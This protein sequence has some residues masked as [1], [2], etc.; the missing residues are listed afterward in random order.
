MTLLRLCTDVVDMKFGNTSSIS[1][2]RWVLAAASACVAPAL[3]PRVTRAADIEAL[4]SSV[5]RPL[6]QEYDIPGL[7]VGLVTQG[8][9]HFLELGVSARQGGRATSRDTLFEIGS[10]S[11]C[12]T[13][14]LAALAQLKGHLH[15]DQPVEEIVKS[16]QG[17]PIGRAS[18]MHLATY[19]AGGLPLQFPD[20]VTSP[21]E[22]LAYFST[23]TPS[24]APGVIRNY[25]NPSIGLLG[26]ATAL[27]LA[28]DFS[29]LSERDLFA[30]LGLDSTFIKVPSAQIHRYAWGH[31]KSQ[32]QVRVNPGVFDAQ[33]YGV[34]STASD[35][36]TFLQAHLDPKALPPAIRGAIAQTM[37]PRY[38]AGPMQQGMGW[39][40]YPWPYSTDALKEGNGP[41]TVFEPVTVHPVQQQIPSTRDMTKET[42]HALVSKATRLLPE[43]GAP[44]LLN[45]TGS[46]FGFGAYVAMV[47]HRQTALVMLAN[48]NLPI[49]ARVSAAMQ[50]L[51]KIGVL[52]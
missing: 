46:T 50:V 4:L 25:S 1:R 42:E 51:E 6:V 21:Q 32:K 22:A 16:L 2:R 29:D 52:S 23:F 44:L 5:Y 11:K 30:P 18:L 26:H 47:P 39:E 20:Q 40:I 43:R 41:R 37:A 45:K 34:K 28:G 14:T 36:L 48:R 27:A 38:Q 31:D 17:A 19:T 33:A 9:R 7:A 15:L 13:S 35:M 10:I 49:S 8:R 12:F 24:A 3:I